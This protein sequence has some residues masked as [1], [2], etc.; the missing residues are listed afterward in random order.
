MVNIVSDFDEW[1]LKF[2]TWNLSFQDLLR[3]SFT[4]GDDEGDEVYV[5]DANS[6]MTRYMCSKWIEFYH[7]AKTGWNAAKNAEIG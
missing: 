2:N 7:A 5:S 4:P 6:V 1:F 3:L